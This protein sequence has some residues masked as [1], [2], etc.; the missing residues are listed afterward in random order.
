VIDELAAH[1]AEARV[2]LARIERELDATRSRGAKQ[3]ADRKLWEERA[4]TTGTTDREKA[5][6]CV[7]RMQQLDAELAATETQLTGLA[8]LKARIQSTLARAE[9]RLAILR[10]RRSELASREACAKVESTV[11]T[12]ERRRGLDADRAFE[13]WER[14]VL[15]SEYA[16][17][18]PAGDELA[19]GFETAEE[20]DRLE[21]ELD[22]LLTKE[23]AQ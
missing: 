14:D 1:A 13:R 5:L 8:A 22:R 16:N 19:E 9:S 2:H 23:G 4:R 3:R 18:E 17:G 11:A 12:H 7:K 6:A 10:R 20:R 21:A 15:R